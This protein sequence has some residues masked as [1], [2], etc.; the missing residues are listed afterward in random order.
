M[1]RSAP[2]RNAQHGA[3]TPLTANGGALCKSH[4]LRR[5]FSLHFLP[6]QYITFYV[7]CQAI[8]D[9]KS[10]KTLYELVGEIYAANGITPTTDTSKWGE[11]KAVLLHKAEEILMKDLPVIP[12]IFTQ[13]AVVPSDQ[14]THVNYKYTP[15]YYPSYFTKMSLKDYESYMYFDEKTQLPVS[16]FEEFPTISWDR[17]GK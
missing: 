4:T 17:V 15:Y 3:N 1:T 8:F 12:V 11:Q 13:N 5:T 6:K 14:L 2:R 10:A 7:S 16:I 9:K